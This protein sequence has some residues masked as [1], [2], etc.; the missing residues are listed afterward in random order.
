MPDKKLFSRE[1]AAEYLG[2]STRTLDRIRA[3][4]RI[5]YVKLG[6]SGGRIAYLRDDIDAFIA[7]QRV[8]EKRVPLTPTTTWRHRRVAT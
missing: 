8:S 7:R 4:G 5:A 1:E 2:V 3:D 6:G